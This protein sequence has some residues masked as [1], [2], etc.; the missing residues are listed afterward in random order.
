MCGD[1][2]DVGNIGDV[3]CGCKCVL[4]RMT[5]QLTDQNWVQGVPQGVYQL[6][7][8]FRNGVYCRELEQ[9]DFGRVLVECGTGAGKINIQ[10]IGV[11]GHDTNAPNDTFMVR[12]N[13]NYMRKQ[14][15]TTRSGVI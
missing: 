5:Q 15:L 11:G 1:C 3:L 12:E 9:G 4:V 14:V 13:F 10:S 8:I 2:V 7:G 6:Y